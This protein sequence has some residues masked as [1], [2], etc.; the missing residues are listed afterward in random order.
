MLSSLHVVLLDL[1]C[2]MPVIIA[3][4]PSL[5]QRCCSKG[6]NDILEML[7]A[8]PVVWQLISA[9]LTGVLRHGRS[10]LSQVISEAHALGLPAGCN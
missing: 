9:V 1:P 8:M 10:G 3:N 4:V 7:S 2:I 6:T 5:E